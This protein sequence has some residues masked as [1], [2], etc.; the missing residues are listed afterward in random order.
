MLPAGARFAALRLTSLRQAQQGVQV[1]FFRP[2]VDK[3]TFLRSP[4]EEEDALM[5]TIPADQ[6]TVLSLVAFHGSKDFVRSEARTIRSADAS[7]TGGIGRVPSLTLI[8]RL[9]E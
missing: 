2:S 3:L 4:K 6:P 5:A 8:M 7:A 1:S 9:S